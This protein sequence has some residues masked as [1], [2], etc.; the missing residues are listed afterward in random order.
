M[1]AVILAAGKGSR[2]SPLTDKTPKPLLR[3]GD[4]F[5]I[6]YA[7][8]ALP[9]E[10]REVIVVVGH[11]GEE[12]EKA[13][14]RSYCSLA[15]K[16]AHTGDNDSFRGTAGALWCA[17]AILTSERFFV[18]GA[19]D[20]IFRSD[21]E[22]FLPY[23]RGF[24]V[25]KTLPPDERFLNVDISKEGLI[26]GLSTIKKTKKASVLATG[27][28]LLDHAIF[29]YEPARLKSGELGLPQT[30]IKLTSNHP[31]NAVTMTSWSPVN[32][33]QDYLKVNNIYSNP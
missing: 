24:G 10:V 7:L 33:V 17:R 19:D 32:T 30:V 4:A 12:I 13:I 23:Q 8:N 21:L 28:Y 14:G 16:Y 29:E 22:K 5:L 3:V 18:T 31:V 26:K 9:A 6:H 1:Q 20:I 15:I 25:H 2:L 27:C 11:M